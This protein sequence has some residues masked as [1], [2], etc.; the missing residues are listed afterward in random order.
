MKKTY[1][2]K[3]YNLIVILITVLLLTFCLSLICELL[4]D[5]FRG[6]ITKF[7]SVFWGNVVDKTIWL[8]E[9]S[10]KITVL[11]VLVSILLV[12]VEAYQRIR[13]DSLW[14]SIRSIYQTIRLRKFLKQKNNHSMIFEDNVITSQESIQEQFN[15]AVRCSS[16]DVKCNKVQAC[17][18]IPRTQQ[19]Q[20]LLKEMG[21]DIREEIASMNKDFYFSHP[22]REGNLLW[23][24][25]TRR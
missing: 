8:S 4:A 11:L 16:L 17:I 9:L 12:G 19:S 15:R 13:N 3:I 23:F 1:F 21:E 2:Q 7:N 25:G 10:R 14:N 24:I 5:F 18:K 20:R 6:N 22:N